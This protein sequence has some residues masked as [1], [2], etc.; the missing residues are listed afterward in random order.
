[1]RKFDDCDI[2]QISTVKTFPT[3]A[4]PP[5]QSA[6]DL[7][8]LMGDLVKNMS[9]LTK[10][11]KTTIEQQQTMYQDLQAKLKRMAIIIGISLIIGVMGIIF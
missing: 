4:Q 8:P 5:Y 6:P 2:F 1:M 9:L 3:P 11:H 10:S 7:T